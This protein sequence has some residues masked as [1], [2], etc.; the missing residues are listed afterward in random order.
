MSLLG[1]LDNEKFSGP[2]D[3][4]LDRTFP[5]GNRHIVVCRCSMD[6]TVYGYMGIDMTWLRSGGA[7]DLK[8]MGSLPIKGE[9][10]VDPMDSKVVVKYEPPTQGEQ[11]LKTWI[12]PVS[13]IVHMPKSLPQT[14]LYYKLTTL[15]SREN[16]RN[17]LIEVSELVLVM[18]MQLDFNS[19]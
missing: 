13:F 19:R 10:I 5:T 18:V 16:I 7:A 3:I 14:P 4:L 2:C 17:F 15:Y 11:L 1:V 8:L 6:V 9:L 12:K